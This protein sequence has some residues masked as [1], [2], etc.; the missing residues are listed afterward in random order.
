[1]ARF[2]YSP[3]TEFIN[4][5]NKMADVDKYAD[6]MLDEAAPILVDSL[7]RQL[8]NHKNTGDLQ[9]SIKASR[10]KKN[11]YGWYVKVYPAGTDS[12][13]V[14]N[15]EKLAYLEYGTSTQPAN[16]VME[17]A[18]KDCEGEILKCMRVIS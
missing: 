3:P 10:A 16:P 14:R 17:K 5:L 6:K 2:E 8:N 1:M 9:K 18:I 12:K 4:Q 7:K 15:G 13:G 11:K